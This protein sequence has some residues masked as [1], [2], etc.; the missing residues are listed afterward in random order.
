MWSYGG[1]FPGLDANKC[2]SGHYFGFV[3]LPSNQGGPATTNRVDVTNM[4]RPWVAAK[5]PNGVLGVSVESDVPTY[6]FKSVAASLEVV[7]DQSPPPVTLSS[8]ADTATITTLTPTLGSNTVTDPDGE[9]VL[10]RAVLSARDPGSLADAD[11]ATA[12]GA[13]R[14]GVVLDVGFDAIVRG[15]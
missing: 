3:W 10:Y 13:Q 8:P 15:A 4:I 12:C 11:P 14:G 9:P 5:D 1:M 7:W 2:R 6:N